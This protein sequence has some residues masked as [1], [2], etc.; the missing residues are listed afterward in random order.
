MTT[1]PLY[2]G[3]DGGNTKSLAV[4][5]DAKGRVLGHGR[6]RCGDIYGGTETSLRTLRTVVGEALGEAGVKPDQVA[7]A[8]F[9]LAGADWPEDFD[10]LSQELGS[11][12]WGGPWRVFNDAQ[13]ALRGCSVDGFGVAMVCGTFGTV[14]AKHPNGTEWF[15]G[16]FCT[17]GGGT[18][19]GKTGLH[20]VIHAHLGVAPATR[21]TEELMAL[22]G[23]PTPAEA[24]KVFTSRVDGAAPSLA[25]ITPAVV[26]A[27]N[28]GDA[29]A[30]GIL[31]RAADELAYLVD[32]AVRHTGLADVFTV[33][34]TGGMP[35]DPA[36]AWARTLRERVLSMYPKV[37]YRPADLEPLGGAVML[38]TD[39]LGLRVEREW[40]EALKTGLFRLK[41]ER[42]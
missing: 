27:A 8:A 3:L 14:A 39:L 15:A 34:Q 32:A 17:A 31:G 9:S 41:E 36:S 2:L 24:V 33:Y 35:K 18:G 20:A 7:A 11:L 13:G 40:H 10:L 16:P 6:G 28:S 19:I 4:I 42:R 12:G 5:V 21:I 26:A 23:R 1:S 30:L 37:E 22:T 25:G 29:V 38:A